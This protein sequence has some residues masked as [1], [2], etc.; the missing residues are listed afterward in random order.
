MDPVST[1]F[2]LF[3]AHGSSDYVG[4][5]VSQRQHALQAAALASAA[6]YPPDVVLAALLHDCGHMIG[7]ADPA[8]FARM[9]DCGA[10]AHEAIGGAWAAK[11]GF[12]ARTADLIRRHVQA[13][14][15]LCHVD[16]SYEGRLSS[17][18]R[19]TLGHQGGPMSAAEAD[20]FSRDP[21]RDTILEMRRWDEA[22]KDPHADVP[23]LEAYRAMMEAAV[24]GGA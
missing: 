10:V 19:T 20:A 22:A 13:K 6:G 15:Y 16:P 2:A 9:G 3:A 14:R 12:P 18:S 1:V 8:N 4:E 24:A 17:A 11:L 7:L 23:P 5:A 21:L